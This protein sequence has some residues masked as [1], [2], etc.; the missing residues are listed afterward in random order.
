M[1]HRAGLS[2]KHFVKNYIMFV[3]A[4]NIFYLDTS[5]A[6]FCANLKR[7]GGAVE[8]RPIHKQ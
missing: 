7:K 8:R 2:V 5:K 1:G 6:S 4:S 3:S